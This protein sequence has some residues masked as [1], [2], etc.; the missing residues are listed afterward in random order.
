MQSASEEKRQ[1]LDQC[2]AME[3]KLRKF[4]AD[5]TQLQTQLQ[6]E[7]RSKRSQE[8]SNKDLVIQQENLVNTNRALQEKVQVTEEERLRM[9]AEAKDS[10][11]QLRE[12]AEKVFQLLERLKLVG[13]AC[14]LLRA[15]ARCCASLRCF[16]YNNRA[17]P[18][19]RSRAA[20]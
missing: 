1:A 6:I 18:S 7:A 19:S 11:E 15:V 20:Q 16:V 17:F 8:A 13:I 10:G 12:M 4:H 5:H 9:E 14:V 2:Q 3:E